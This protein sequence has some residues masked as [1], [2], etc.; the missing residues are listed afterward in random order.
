MRNKLLIPVV[1]ATIVLTGCGNS[2]DKNNTDTS[3]FEQA[4]NLNSIERSEDYPEVS[5]TSADVTIKSIRELFLNTDSNWNESAEYTAAVECYDS[6]YETIVADGRQKHGESAKPHFAVEYID[7]DDIPALLVSYG[8]YHVAGIR[9]YTYNPAADEVAYIGEFSS[10]GRMSFSEK[11]NSIHSS[12][13]NQGYFIGLY[14]AIKDGKASLIGAELS[15][16]S[17]LR[18]EDIL[19][20]YGFNVPE[21]EDGTREA[22]DA[23]SDG[24][25]VVISDLSEEHLVSLEEYASVCDTLSGGSSVR[26]LTVS[27][28]EPRNDEADTVLMYAIGE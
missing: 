4:D 19:Y 24:E 11:K 27:Y 14:T 9:V 17:G 15:D 5:D 3:I 16:G 21:W 7:E 1:M 2:T 13:G 20:Y 18:S 25:E 23:N 12:Y 10:Y 6:G 28:D 8:D 22:F 26:V